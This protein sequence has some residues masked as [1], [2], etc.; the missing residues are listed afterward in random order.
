VG[1]IDEHINII[2]NRELNV[3]TTLFIAGG[4]ALILFG[5]RFLRKG[6]DRLFGARLGQLMQRM[7]DTRIKAFLSGIIVSLAAPS[8]TTV[9][10]LAVQT[11][12]A[13]YITTRQMLAVMFGADIGLTVM[14]ALIALRVEQYA[15]ILALVGVGMFQFSDRREVRG[16]GQVMLSVS[17]I[18]MGIATIKQAAGAVQLNADAMQLI[19]ILEHYPWL[20]ALAAIVMAVALQSSTAT[21]GL[22]IGLGA[23]DAISLPTAMAV[24]VGANVGIVCT[25]LI[26]G[27]SR[28]ETRRVAV[29]NLTVKIIVAV[30]A[31]VMLPTA[32]AW[33]SDVPGG[34]DRQV[35]ISH[36]TFNLLVAAIGMPLVGPVHRFVTWLV[37]APPSDRLPHAPR[38]LTDRPP[39]SEALALGQSMRE[40]SHVGEIVRG[41]MADT[42][43][44]LRN[45]DAVLARHVRACDD[46]VDRL[47]EAI[48][49]F[50]IRIG[51]EGGSDAATEQMHQFRY[52]SELETIGDIIDRNLVDLVT[53][54]AR[55]GGRLS[56]Q[57]LEP[58]K[59]F[60]HAVL[61]N[62][63]IAE[64][65]FA[66][67]D[68]SLARE[69]IGQTQRIAN[70]EQELR[71]AH[72]ARLQTD[73]SNYG[74]SSAIFLD[75]L[76]HLKQINDH[77]MHMGDAVFQP[78][79]ESS[80]LERRAATDPP[81]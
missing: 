18:F 37:P 71:D 61:Q 12:R 76:T 66:T 72:F 73:L 29:G 54:Q 24:V 80:E 77:V 16:V 31:L 69:L 56:S 75:L 23:A 13:R 53:K 26:V 33:L 68:R 15:P 41:M 44:A 27:W 50:L 74:E 52:L 35:A 3:L 6:L 42:W 78:N 11:A 59:R 39:E 34:M 64:T 62:M 81:R 1:R 22:V 67:R 21:I 8:S 63:E 38:Y 19:S 28:V 43:R 57:D 46:Y 65:A 70:L 51:P 48:K 14:V 7:A 55:V 5:A 9:S 58:L 4:V 20:L 10:I 32:A 36:T 30:S 45:N 2:A 40:I 79:G 17:F 60:H 47:D 25:M 49:R